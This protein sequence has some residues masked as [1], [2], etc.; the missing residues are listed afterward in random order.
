MPH[1]VVFV[2]FR[3]DCPADNRLKVTPPQIW[4]KWICW[5]KGSKSRIW[6]S[7]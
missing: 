5:N 4:T 7:V 3:Y 2:I 1:T 6:C